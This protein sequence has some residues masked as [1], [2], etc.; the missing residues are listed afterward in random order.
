ME[1]PS[2]LWLTETDDIDWLVVTANDAASSLTHGVG[3]SEK[4]VVWGFLA[5][6]SIIVKGFVFI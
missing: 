4:V 5:T 3:L 6:P 2:S 1:G